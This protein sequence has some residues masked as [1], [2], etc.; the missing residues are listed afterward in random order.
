M[1]SVVA[2]HEN[3][4][5]PKW[6]MHLVFKEISDKQPGFFGFLAIYS[7]GSIANAD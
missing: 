3:S 2:V 6:A 1:V 7:V 4:A 5:H